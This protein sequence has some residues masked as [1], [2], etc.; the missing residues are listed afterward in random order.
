MQTVCWCWPS[1]VLPPPRVTSRLT[2]RWS[3]SHQSPGVSLAPRWAP[4]FVC[5]SRLGNIMTLIHSQP[6]TVWIINYS[7]VSSSHSGGL[8]EIVDGPGGP[9]LPREFWSI[10]N[11]VCDLPDHERD[12]PEEGGRG[13]QGLTRGWS[14]RFTPS[15]MQQG[16][17]SSE[18]FSQSKHYFLS[19]NQH[20]LSHFRPS[21]L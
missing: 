6:V 11:S 16:P 8:S 17:R 12:G 19:G 4:V 3:P 13:E 1:L 9:E 14:V 15:S 2:N 10:N 20:S 5:G 21:W 18:W 7:N